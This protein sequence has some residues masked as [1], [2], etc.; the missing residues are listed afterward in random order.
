MFQLH[1]NTDL[2]ALADIL[3]DLLARRDPHNPLLPETVLVP[4]EGLQRW[5]VQRMAERHGIAANLEFLRPAAFVW[6]LLRAVRPDLPLQSAFDRETLRWRLFGL[7]EV[8]D[9]E[10]EPLRR[11]HHATHLAQLF[12]QYQGYRRDLLDAW[13]RGAETDDAQARLWRALVAAAKDEP[14]RNTLIGDYLRRHGNDGAAPPPGLPRRLFAFGCINVSPDVLHLLSTVARHAELHF[15]L[16]TPCRE[17]WGNVES[18]R[19]ARRAGRA[20]FDMPDNPLLV[21]F[22]GVGRE[23]VAELFNDDSIHDELADIGEPPRDNLL[24][25][26]QADVVEL[27]APSKEAR[28]AAIDPADRSIQV[29]VCHSPLREVQVLHDRLIDMLQCDPALEPRDIAVLVPDIAAY[30]PCVEAVFGALAPDDP[31]RIPWSIS[32]RAA[33]ATHA[34][35]AMFLRLL[36]LPASRLGLDEVLDTLAVPAVQRRAGLAGDDIDG[37]RRSAAAA[38]IVW[39]EDEADRTVHDLPP[40]RE[41]SWAFGRERVLLG[42]LRGDDDDH[43]LAHGIAPIGDVEGD[44]VEA[45]GQLL[46]VERQLRA[47]AVFQREAHRARDWQ[48]RLNQALTALLPERLEDDEQRAAETI[49]AALATL[50]LHTAAAGCDE[51]L[52]WQCVRAFLRERLD[53]VPARQRFLEGGVSI[54]G[55]VPLRSVPFRVICVLGLD[56]KAFPRRDPGDVL[57][58]L[59]ADALA[60]RRRSGDRSRREDD[61]YLFLQTLMAARDVLYLGYTGIEQRDGTP[62]EPSA[63]LSEFLDVVCEGY[64]RN[65]KAARLALVTQHPMRP[66]SPKLFDGSDAR[67]YTYR[68]E[69]RAA[70]QPGPTRA[71]RAFAAADWPADEPVVR[72][73]LDEL[74]RFLRAPQ[75]HFLLRRAGIDVGDAPQLNDEREPLVDNPLHAAQRERRLLADLLA[76]AS[77][78]A[79]QLHR[80]LAASGL[81]PPL[82]LGDDLFV[83]SLREVSPQAALWRERCGDEAQPAAPFTLAMPSGRVIDGSLAL[84]PRGYAG[85]VGALRSV[86]GWTRWWL[87][88]LVAR[89][90]DGTLPCLAFGH[91]DDKLAMPR[92][93]AVPAGDAAHEVLDRLLDVYVEG[94][95]R[96]V[97]MPPRSGWAYAR[98]LAESGNPDKALS[99]A[100]KKWSGVHTHDDEKRWTESDDPWI[101]LALDGA[102]LFDDA[103]VTER[104][105]DL[106]ERVYA[107]VW[108]AIRGGERA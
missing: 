68:H 42:Y 83:Q 101:A 11:F 23:F 38:G 34:I 19:E 93:L 50:A 41:F 60:G 17:Y 33:G 61:R 52:D 94:C 14:P 73:A 98:E 69:W 92:A 66:F 91:G 106:A 53:E 8:A 74:A 15:M 62:R 67:F 49:R 24:H 2:D 59:D 40:Y 100:R 4:Q 1:Y 103:E 97:P 71:L 35:T 48:A 12:E 80:R 55:M 96:P 10:P 22:G 30:A 58:R 108:Q 81:L 82:A 5:L 75:K 63:V 77:L 36:G 44:R 99:E 45:F 107:P 39:G 56:A 26:V 7:P 18:R 87:E 9:A 85:W 31:R 89:A 57:S 16:P 13:Q 86:S 65:E 43:D 37:L 72:V 102:G 20:T 84:F 78:P 46:H 29:H 25:R 70:A 54:C 47:L 28:T 79:A 76:D 6:R 3:A 51:A 32:D 88:A 21:S 104:F 90:Q 105:Q 95:M 64:F 27:K